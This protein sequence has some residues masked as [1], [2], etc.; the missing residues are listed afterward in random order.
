[1]C[2]ITVIFLKYQ[3]S[4]FEVRISWVPIWFPT[5]ISC[6]RL[7]FN[8]CV[9]FSSFE[10]ELAMTSLQNYCEDNHIMHVY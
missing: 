5:F 7:A 2:K 3:Y 8:L 4:L 10:M 9:V 1:M 6:V